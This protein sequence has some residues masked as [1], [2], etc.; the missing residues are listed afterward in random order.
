MKHFTEELAATNHHL[1]ALI[2]TRSSQ[3]ATDVG[4]TLGIS[5]NQSTCE[6]IRSTNSGNKN[7]LNMTENAIQIVIEAVEQQP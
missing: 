3:A 2:R 1:P 7:K 5:S 6:R 4:A